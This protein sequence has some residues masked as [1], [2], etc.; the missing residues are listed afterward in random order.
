MDNGTE[1]KPKVQLS[2][3]DGNAFT[4]LGRC[5]RAAKRAGWK[6]GRISE[7]RNKATSGDYDNLLRVCMEYFDVE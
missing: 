7:W 6:E 2:G 5:Q 3:E 4:I 1:T